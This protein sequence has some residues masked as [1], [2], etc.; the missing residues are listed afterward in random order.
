VPLSHAIEQAANISDIAL[1]NLSSIVE[2]KIKQAQKRIAFEQVEKEI[3]AA[4]IEAERAVL[5]EAL[6]KY[7]ID[8]PTVMN[9]GKEYHQ[10]LRCE[11]TYISAV[12]QMKR[13][14]FVRWSC[15]RALLKAHGVQP[16]QNKPFWLCLSLHPM[17]Q[18]IYLVSLEQCNPQK[19]VWIDCLKN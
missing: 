15:V 6:A 7:D 4:F 10:V 13:K 17:R 12:G 16:L 19:A 18:P 14:V 5:S 9:E 2:S 8:L 11:Q 3:H 1:N